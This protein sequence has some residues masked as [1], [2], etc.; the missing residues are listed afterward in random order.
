MKKLLFALALLVVLGTACG[1]ATDTAPGCSGNCNP[2]AGVNLNSDITVVYRV[3]GS[4]K[5]ASMTYENMQGGTE[6]GDYMLPFTKTLR[7][8]GNVPNGTFLYISAQN[9]GETG[10]VTCEILVNGT[11]QKTSTSSGAYVICDA[12]MSIWH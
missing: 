3:T 7:F 10:T 8:I 4:A 1:T 2:T 6:Q 5:S 11:V 9:D 12:S